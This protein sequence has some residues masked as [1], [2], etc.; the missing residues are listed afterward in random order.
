MIVSGN[1]SSK[2]DENCC[3][4]TL[5]AKVERKAKSSSMHLSSLRSAQEHS[6]TEKLV[7]GSG[8]PENFPKNFTF[9]SLR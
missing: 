8:I 6:D 1:C 7:M 9:Q 3:I 5:K 4:Y 2:N